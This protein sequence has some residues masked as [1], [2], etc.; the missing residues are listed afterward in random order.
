[1]KFIAHRGYR[2]C[3]P[4]NTLAAFEAV[5]NHPQNGKNLIGI[6]L[7]IH[8]TSDNRIIVMHSTEIETANKETVAVADITHAQLM[9]CA[10]RNNPDKFAAIPDIDQTLQLVNHKT[11]LCFEIKQAAYNRT[12]FIARLI[13][14]L[15]RYKPEN[16]V[17][18]SSFSHEI[19]W[20]IAEAAKHVDVK[21]AF[22]FRTLDSL[23]CLPAKTKERLNYLHP[24]HKLLLKYPDAFE[25]APFPLQCWTV[26]T[27]E[28]ID[29]I[30]ALPI[31]GAIRSIMTDDI[32]F[33]QRYGD[34]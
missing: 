9:E 12:A 15:H 23:N 31:A 1:M 28:E 29:A 20:V 19:L 13:E 25:D 7:D 5:I 21:Y 22:I 8:A 11:E 34:S 10:A 26:N 27:P 16:D 17:V 30:L 32:A 33:S 6:E 4:E 14:S 2:K 24:N 3:Y 18:I